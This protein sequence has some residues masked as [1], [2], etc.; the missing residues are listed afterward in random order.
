MLLLAGISQIGAV[1]TR[2]AALPP[3]A[4][5]L[6][7][8]FGGDSSTEGAFEGRPAGRFGCSRACCGSWAH[9]SP[10]APAAPRFAPIRPPQRVILARGRPGAGSRRR[11]PAAPPL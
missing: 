5:Q 3:N 2:E 10:S 4:S 11:A 1:G 9:G 8:A 7:G 6:R